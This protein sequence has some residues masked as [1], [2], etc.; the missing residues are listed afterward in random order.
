MGYPRAMV[1]RHALPLLS[2]IM[3][4]VPAP[5]AAELPEAVRVMLERAIDSGTAEEVDTIARY[6]RATH[7][8][9]AEAIDAMIADYNARRSEARAAAAAA[10]QEA[11]RTA[12]IFE[13]WEGRGEVGFSRATGNSDELGA[14]IGFDAKREGVDWNHRLRA[15]YNVR[16]IE[17]STTRENILASYEPRYQ[18]DQGL[19]AFGL[20]QF[21]RAPFQGFDARYAVSGGLGYQVL[22][23][24]GFSLAIKGGPALRMT[25]FVDGR[26][27]EH[28]AGLL[29][30]DFDWTIVDNVKLTQDTNLLA[31]TGGSAVAIFDGSNTSFDLV[32]GLEGA[33]G[34]GLTARLAYEVDYDSNPPP[35]AVSTDTL[36]R[37]TLV[38]GF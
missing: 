27:E 30:L 4:A 10:E 38:Y 5:A 2:V 13:N 14:T 23:G 26:S 34:G 31:E 9:G 21:E 33:L 32:T 29:A 24:D 28:L 1:A 18:I 36:T 37:F 6:A 17:G 35:G 7:P 25:D 11:I 22:D 3:V 19:F 16:R 15:R 20:A 12:G 8:E